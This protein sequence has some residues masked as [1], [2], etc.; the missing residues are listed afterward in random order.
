VRDRQFLG[1]KFRRQHPVNGF[2]LDFYCH[3]AKLGIE[4][5]GGQ[6]FEP[7][8]AQYD[9]ERSNILKELGIRVVRFR[10]DDVLQNTQAVM[11]AV[12]RA[13]VHDIPDAVR[14]AGPQYAA[15]ENLGAG[16]PAVVKQKGTLTP[17][18]PSTL[19][20]TLS[21]REREEERD[22]SL[23]SAAL[24]TVQRSLHVERLASSLPIGNGDALEPSLHW[25]VQGNNA[26]EP[27]PHMIMQGD[28]SSLEPSPLGR[29]QGEGSYEFLNLIIEVSGEARKDK[30]AKVSTARNLWIP[31]VNNHGGFGKWAF[32]EISDPW[33]AKNTIR[34]FIIECIRSLIL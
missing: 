2:I 24:A 15:Q 21:Q 16:L 6:H 17:T 18:Q 13:L 12:E 8:N 3:Q 7:E 11:V 14:E 32:V 10:N 9:E 4:L 1:Y 28:G 22:A 23:N 19:T 34:A 20:P 29:G 25:N 5:D 30:A 33:D 27:S 26:L 31:A